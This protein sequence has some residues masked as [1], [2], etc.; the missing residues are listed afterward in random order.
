MKY[1]IIIKHPFR[2]YDWR[3]DMVD[4]E[5]PVDQIRKQIENEMLGPFEVMAVTP[6]IDFNRKLKTEIK[7]NK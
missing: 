3:V 1:A 4:T 2:D 6:K 5:L 7:E